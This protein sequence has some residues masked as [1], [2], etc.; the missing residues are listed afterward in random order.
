MNRTELT[1]VI[2]QWDAVVDGKEFYRVWRSDDPEGAVSGTSVRN[3]ILYLIAP[4]NST[5]DRGRTK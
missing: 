4:P 3:C 5:A 1:F 2:E